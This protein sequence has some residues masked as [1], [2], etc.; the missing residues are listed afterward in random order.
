MAIDRST[1]RKLAEGLLEHRGH[2][3]EITY[4]G[5][6]PKDERRLP[7]NVT[8]ECLDCGEVLIDIDP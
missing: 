5:T 2:E 4:Y 6:M 7:E 1:D 8:L 3:I